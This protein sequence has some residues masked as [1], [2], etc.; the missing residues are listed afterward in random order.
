MGPLAGITVIE[1]AGL[2]P[3]PFCGMMLSDM[4]AD[5]IRIERKGHA[6]LTEP[7][8]DVMMRNRR[9]IGI[10]LRKAEGVEIVLDMVER[11]DALQ[12]GSLILGPMNRQECWL[13]RWRQA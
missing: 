5:V 12:E 11:A 4:G 6:A 3:G 2:A 7:K 8:Y 13:R 9:S 10:D 1:L